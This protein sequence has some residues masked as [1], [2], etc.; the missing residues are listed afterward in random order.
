MPR[1]H[2]T[3]GDLASSEVADTEGMSRE[4]GGCSKHD[5]LGPTRRQPIFGSRAAQVSNCSEGNAMVECRLVSRPEFV[6]GDTAVGGGGFAA[7]RHVTGVLHSFHP[8]AFALPCRHTSQEGHSFSVQ[9]SKDPLH[10]AVAL[11]RVGGGR[12]A[13]DS[14]LVQE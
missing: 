12:I 9:K 14:H 7:V 11:G 5:A 2:L 6:R 10:D 3:L 13:L 8:E 1:D 4:G